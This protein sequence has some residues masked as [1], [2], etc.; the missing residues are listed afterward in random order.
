MQKMLDLSIAPFGPRHPKHVQILIAHAWA[1]IWKEICIVILISFF[2]T[3]GFIYTYFT[4][5]GT[6]YT[7]TRI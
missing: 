5:F 1:I 7:S 2:I 3:Y 6:Q 4:Y